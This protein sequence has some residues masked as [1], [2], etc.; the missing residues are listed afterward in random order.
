MAANGDEA[1]AVVQT[2]RSGLARFAGSE[3]HQPT[4]IE[5]A[6]VQLRI[7]RDGRVGVAAG[8]RLDDEG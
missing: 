1:E 6:G 8:N 4:L 7:V 5:N 2:E 3:V